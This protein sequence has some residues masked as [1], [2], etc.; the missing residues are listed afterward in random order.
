MT[1]F[2]PDAPY[3]P[4]APGATAMAAWQFPPWSG[5]SVVQGVAAAFLEGVFVSVEFSPGG[6]NKDTQVPQGRDCQKG[7]VAGPVLWGG[8]FTWESSFNRL[9]LTKKTIGPAAW[10]VGGT[11]SELILR[12]FPASTAVCWECGWWQSF[13]CLV[14]LTC[15]GGWWPKNG[16][17]RCL[18]GM[19]V[20]TC[21]KRMLNEAKT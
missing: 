3:W 9:P 4:G 1:W 5:P 21:W 14:S 13:Q 7:P 19:D 12:V 20:F 8:W 10:S 16:A 18:T 15:V 2:P 11:E 17:I 6:L